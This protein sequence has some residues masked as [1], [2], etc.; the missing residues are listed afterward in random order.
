V[1]FVVDVDGS[2]GELGLVTTHITSIID[3]PQAQ[4]L[5]IGD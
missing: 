5:A 4:V 1:H 2:R 3:E